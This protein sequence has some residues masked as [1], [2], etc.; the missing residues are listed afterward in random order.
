M[1]RMLWDKPEDGFA[2]ALYARHVSDQSD[3]MVRL[4][5]PCGVQLH[6]GSNST[7]TG[8]SNASIG[9]GACLVLGHLPVPESETTTEE[10]PRTW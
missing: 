8:A 7:G 9:N 6:A 3:R 10:P 4:W 2:P 5:S 1:A